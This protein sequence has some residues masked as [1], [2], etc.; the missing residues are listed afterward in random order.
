[1]KKTLVCLTEP[2][3]PEI[4]APSKGDVSML[5]LRRLAQLLTWTVLSLSS[6]A[7]AQSSVVLLHQQSSSQYQLIKQMMEELASQGKL[8]D[9]I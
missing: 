6:S 1:V 9:H 3:M 4:N 7:F 2:P 5:R 8:D